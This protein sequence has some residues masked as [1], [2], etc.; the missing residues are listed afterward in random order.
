LI[1]FVTMVRPVRHASHFGNVHAEEFVRYLRTIQVAANGHLNTPKR[2]LMDKGIRY[3]L[4]T[5]RALFNYAG[6]WRH[7][8]P[9][10]ENPFAMLEI[11]RIPVEDA[12][13][14]TLFTPEQERAFLEA[15]DDWHFP[16][17]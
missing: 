17:F 2:P 4:E 14:I 1:R 7:L 15:C 10:A 12:R 8:P 5:C 13:P 6:K 11:D 16:M 3:I 9:Y